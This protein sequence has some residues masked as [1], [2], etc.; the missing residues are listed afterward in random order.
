MYY[1]DFETAEMLISQARKFPVEFNS[2]IGNPD[3][4]EKMIEVARTMQQSPKLLQVSNASPAAPSQKSRNDE[5]SVP[6]PTGDG[7]G[8]ME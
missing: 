5:T 3:Q 6:G 8:K 7:S 2:D 4:L 1:Q